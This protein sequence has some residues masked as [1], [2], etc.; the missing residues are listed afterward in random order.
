MGTHIALKV[1]VGEF[2]ILFKFEK[3]AELGIGENTTSVLGVLKLMSTDVSVNLTSYLS[4]SH[5]SSLGLSKETSELKANLSGLY[6]TTGSSVTRLTLLATLLG[7]L[8]ELAVS[9]LGKSTNLS[10][11][12]GE[13]RTKRGQ[14]SE[15][16]GELV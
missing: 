2:I 10:S 7:S 1:E 9:A 8:F 12:S 15:K 6:K 11:Y 16:T 4:A 3:L 14:L 13:L 5:L